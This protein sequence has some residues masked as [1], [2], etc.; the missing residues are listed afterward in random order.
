[1]VIGRMLYGKKYKQK[2]PFRAGGVM[3]TKSHPTMTGGY[4]GWFYRCMNDRASEE[5]TPLIVAKTTKNG[6]L[7]T[8]QNGYS[9][10]YPCTREDVLKTI[11]QHAYYGHV[12]IMDIPELD[13]YYERVYPSNSHESR[14]CSGLQLSSVKNEVVFSGLDRKKDCGSNIWEPKKE[15]P[16]WF[17]DY[18]EII[19]DHF[20][21]WRSRKEDA[22]I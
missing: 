16:L 5:S 13:G 12:V 4:A 18:T 2:T 6:V 9:R 3:N 14:V 15:I 17:R 21:V 7:L 11:F 19:R 22:Y 20:F 1:M 10:E 8:A